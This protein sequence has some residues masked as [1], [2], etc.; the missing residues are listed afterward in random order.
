M[1]LPC[2]IPQYTL[3]IINLNHVT[4]VTVIYGGRI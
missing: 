2:P 1:K 4:E 3:V